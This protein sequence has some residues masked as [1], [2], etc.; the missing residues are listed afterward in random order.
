MNPNPKSRY[1]IQIG[2]I[3]LLSMNDTLHIAF[4][5][6]G[7][8]GQR[9]AQRLLDH[10][11][12]LTVWNRTASAADALV[13]S[14]ATLAA[15]PADAAKGA[16]LVIG[17]VTD[18]D[19]SDT[20]WCHPETGAL[21][22][23]APDALAIACSTLT[24]GWVATLS[25]RVTATGAR[26]IDAPLAGSRP[27]AEAGA[28]IFLAGG[29]ASDVTRA[30]PALRA[31]GKAV[32]HAGPIGSGAIMKLVVNGLFGVQ[33][34]VLAE[35]LGL[36]QAS[37]ITPD[38]AMDILAEMPVT[39]PAATI[40]G[41]LMAA[42][43]FAPLFPIDLVHKDFRY[44]AEA[45]TAVGANAPTAAA[46]QQVYQNARDAGFGG[47]NITGVAQLYMDVER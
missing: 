40:M 29:D 26:F 20:I 34:A 24:P 18:D 31:M 43:K 39:S 25:E 41:R 32:H 19:A 15:T 9:M 3:T 28:L 10:G 27:Q 42:Q 22:G 35:L 2:A 1:Q 44:V 30:E 16:Q 11:H 12:T 45:A 33:V 21:Q 4:L 47:D 8:M 17:M 14:G 38:R 23:L 5:G 36:A 46:V 13:G 6:L 7:A 37:G